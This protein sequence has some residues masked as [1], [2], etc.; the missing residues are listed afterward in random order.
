MQ[1]RFE[2]LTGERQRQGAISCIAEVFLKDEPLTSHLRVPRTEFMRFLTDL[3]EHASRQALSWVV[4]DD[5]NGNVVGARVVTALL[6]DFI[7]K[8]Q[9]GEKMAIILSFLHRMSSSVELLSEH[10]KLKAVH[11]HMVAVLEG[12][13]GL[14]LAEK[15][16]TTGSRAAFEQGY[17]WSVGEVTS[18]KNMRLLRKIPSFSPLE[19]VHYDE[20]IC[21]DQKPFQGIR[22]HTTCAAYVFRLSDFKGKANEARF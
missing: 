4:I 18:A 3:I 8:H 2:A 10:I 11:T 7:P 20:Y 13:R 15:L 17:E 6:E 9:Y 22:G 14:G 16:L 12:Y 1:L 5:T 21:G 19:L